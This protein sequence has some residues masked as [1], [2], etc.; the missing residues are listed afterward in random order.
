MLEFFYF[1]NHDT[2]EIDYTYTPNA[3]DNSPIPSLPISSS[4]I[5]TIKF[6]P[7]IRVL[8]SIYANIFVNLSIKTFFFFLHNHISKKYLH[9][10]IYYIYIIVQYNIHFFFFFYYYRSKHSNF[11]YN[12]F[13]NI[14]NSSTF[15]L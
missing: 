7:L 5:Y 15:R 9:H 1:E 6:S 3:L 4:L 14:L 11:N 8:R 10:I 13:V 12:Y 2:L